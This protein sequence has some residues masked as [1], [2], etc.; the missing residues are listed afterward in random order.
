MVL[1]IKSG[2][3]N[4]STILRKLGT[5]SRKNK[6]YKAFQALGCAV[7]TEFLLQYINS[8]DLRAMIQSATN[9]TE[10][11][12]SLVQ[13]LSF[14]G[15]NI[16]ATNIRE[17]QR[18]FLK[19]NHLVANCLIFQNV[20]EVSRILHELVQEGYKVDPAAVAGLSPYL[21]RHINRF[22]RYSLD[23]NRTPQKLNYELPVFSTKAET[24]LTGS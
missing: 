15:D 13:W 12:H 24:V 21:R 2:K 14:G 8:V 3:I 4:A 9:K 11:F 10:S 20:F 5:N 23:V 19:Y 1:S 6:L 17:E 22:G 18:K 16:I 7:R